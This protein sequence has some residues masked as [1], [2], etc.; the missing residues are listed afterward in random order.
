MSLFYRQIHLCWK[1]RVCFSKFPLVVFDS[2]LFSIANFSEQ[3]R[4]AA[5]VYVGSRAPRVRE[6]RIVREKH[7]T[8][9][10]TEPN[11]ILRPA[12]SVESHYWDFCVPGMQTN[13]KTPIEQ[14]SRLKKLSWLLIPLFWESLRWQLLLDA[15]IIYFPSLSNMIRTNVQRKNHYM[16]YSL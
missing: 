4:I 12:K 7:C 3:D 15:P 14:N 13:D 16:F 9:L 2:H 10:K 6:S 11:S 1:W 8:K 5:P